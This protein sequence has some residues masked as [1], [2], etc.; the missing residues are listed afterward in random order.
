MSVFFYE[1]FFSLSNEN[2]AER[3]FR[4][5]MDLHED[6]SGNRVTAWFELPGLNKSD[7]SLDVHNNVLTVSGESR[8]T[9]NLDESG[10]AVRER[11][12]GKFSRSIALPQ[13]IKPEDIKAEM[14]NGVLVVTFPKTTPEMAPKKITIA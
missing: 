9:P 5:R 4:P 3:P 10:F 7:V 8:L 11:R 1:P 2:N 14:A 13:G 6:T 12:F